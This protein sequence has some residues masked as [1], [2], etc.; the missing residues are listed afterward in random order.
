MS[1]DSPWYDDQDRGQGRSRPRQGHFTIGGRPREQER[2]AVH[3]PRPVPAPGPSFSRDSRTAA[4]GKPLVARPPGGQRQAGP[5]LSLPAKII[6]CH[7]TVALY[8]P[9]YECGIVR[10]I[11]QR[12]E[13]CFFVASQVFGNLHPDIGTGVSINAR[14]ME[15]EAPVP[16]LAACVWDQHEHVGPNVMDFLI[17]PPM[18]EHEEC[19]YKYCEELY[20]ELEA[21]EV[22]E[23]QEK[24]R[25]HSPEKPLGD[26]E[27]TKRMRSEESVASSTVLTSVPGLE[28]EWGEAGVTGVV[29]R[30]L[31]DN[32]GEIMVRVKRPVKVLFHA[33][34]VWCGGDSGEMYSPFLE[35][36]PSTELP[37]VAA[38]GQEVRLNA[39]M[40]QGSKYDFQATVVW[41]GDEVPPVNYR[42]EDLIKSLNLRLGQH[43]FLETGD[44]KHQMNPLL[45]AP[46]MAVPARVVEYLTQ[47]IGILKLDHGSKAS[48][49]FH[50]NQ[51][52]TG[53]EEAVPLASV[54]SRLLTTC[55]PLGSQVMVNMRPLPSSQGSKLRYQA[56]CLWP[57]LSDGPQSDQLLPQ[58][59]ERYTPFDERVN[60][61]EE[62][63][64]HHD[65]IKKLLRLQLSPFSEEF[66][67]VQ[68]V[69]MGL[70]NYWQGQV[71]TALNDDIGIIRITPKRGG[72]LASG[73]RSLLVLF[74]IED[75]FDS[76][77]TPAILSSNVSMNAILESYVDLT[78]RPICH[79][80]EPES[81][82]DLQQRIGKEDRSGRIPLLQAIFVCIKDSPD[83]V[84][85]TSN[86][87]KPTPFRNHP[88]NFSMGTT[89]F[90]FNPLLKMKLNL[91]LLNY[92]SLLDSQLPYKTKMKD[93]PTEHEEIKLVAEV[94]KLDANNIQ[95][96]LYGAFPEQTEPMAA[97]VTNS[98]PK[99]VDRVSVKLVFLHRSKLK[100]DS[101]IV[102][103]KLSPGRS[104]KLREPVTVFAYFQLLRYRFFMK[105]DCFADDLANIMP[106]H[107]T[108][109]YFA[110][111][112]LAFP[113]S[114]VPFVVL[115]MWNENL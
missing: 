86:V 95:R 29:E 10:L 97:E 72:E 115:D 79:D 60:L 13:F 48:V 8:Q 81:I 57:Y 41:M 109:N 38:V 89:Q 103:I 67:P 45:G 32:T 36:Y 69:L 31:S 34:Q 70:P 74:H 113:G 101:G 30:F 114:K 98:L 108:E 43:I 15:A 49:L 104:N 28:E 76:F 58:Y 93:F 105:K 102:Q 88:G 62:L 87:P 5:S 107:S 53:G 80:C 2:E 11:G 59:I 110:N 73:V 61:V 111:I 100:T 14:L 82:L 68:A 84:S 40:V 90:Y 6:E 19:Y 55:L 91:K 35:T 44:I 9:E 50:I 51:V 64:A 24:K 12:A 22:Q 77:G 16:Y 92:F 63:D 20:Y 83:A 1:S 47:E 3:S 94:K 17:A 46:D 4:F 33:N 18:P 71:I 78:A 65:N 37:F 99:I 21:Q 96:F 52:W 42:S 56:A 27:R 7:G 66:L 39:R 106:V 85:N 112:E 26:T 54:I 75:V 25:Y 23:P